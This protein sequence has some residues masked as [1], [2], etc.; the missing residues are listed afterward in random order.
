[1]YVFFLLIYFKQ[2][3][4]YFNLLLQK[5]HIFQ[6]EEIR[7]KTAME[8]NERKENK[9]NGKKIHIFLVCNWKKGLYYYVFNVQM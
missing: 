2:L 3:L 5:R 8:P 6:G 1:M 7:I 9:S 4:F